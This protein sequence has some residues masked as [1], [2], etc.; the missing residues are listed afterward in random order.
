MREETERERKKIEKLV[1]ITNK[2]M[3]IVELNKTFPFWDQTELSLVPKQKENHQ[4]NSNQTHFTQIR[5][6]LFMGA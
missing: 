2:E 5:N 1:I 4:Q 6:E 3:Q